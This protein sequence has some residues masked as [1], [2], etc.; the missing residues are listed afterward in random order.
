MNQ[1]KSKLLKTILLKKTSEVLLLIREYYG[2]GTK[3]I[4]SPQ[5][6]Y[7]LFKKLYKEGKIPSNLL[8]VEKENN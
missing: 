2:E 3:N 7:K 1:K 6:L 5:A 8:I 4:E